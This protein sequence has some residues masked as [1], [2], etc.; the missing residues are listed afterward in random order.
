MDALLVFSS[1][2]IVL[3]VLAAFSSALGVDS[4]DGFGGDRLRSGLR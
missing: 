3:V 1:I 2:V 4:R